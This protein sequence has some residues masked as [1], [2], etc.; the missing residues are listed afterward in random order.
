MLIS[1]V[2]EEN[3]YF[4]MSYLILKSDQPVLRVKM[5]KSRPLHLFYKC[6]N[7]PSREFPCTSATNV[8]IRSELCCAL[9]VQH[10]L[11]RYFAVENSSCLLQRFFTVPDHL[12]MLFQNLIY[13]AKKFLIF[14]RNGEMMF[15]SFFFACMIE[16][17][18]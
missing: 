13:I 9:F 12:S 10:D 16:F 6:I 3:K 2:F 4:R 5:N 8:S 11:K 14:W 18:T 7:S 1:L 15:L 17:T